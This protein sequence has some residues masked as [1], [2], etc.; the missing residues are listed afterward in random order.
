[1]FYLYK[2]KNSE[3]WGAVI[4]KYEAHNA[5]QLC[6]ETAV[7]QSK[8]ET[9]E[10]RQLHADSMVNTVMNIESNTRCGQG[11]SQDMW[12]NQQLV[13]FTKNDTLIGTANYR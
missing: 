13:C 9:A 7:T 8:Q 5:E 6:V 12:I 3:C 11:M 10:Q 4:T 2:L 1:M